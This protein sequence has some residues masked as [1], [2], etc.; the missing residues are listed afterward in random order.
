M[1]CTCKSHT[2]MHES[3][4]NGNG[5]GDGKNF[6]G[7]GREWG[8]FSLPCHSLVLIKREC[9]AVTCSSKWNGA[10]YLLVSAI[11]ILSSSLF[12]VDVAEVVVYITVYGQTYLSNSQGWHDI[13]QG[14]ISDTYPYFFNITLLLDVKTSLKCEN[15]ISS[16]QYCLLFNFKTFFTTR[17]T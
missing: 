13:Y 2:S 10:R 9:Q 12:T 7:M 16:F 8:W 14:Y 5:N 17:C 3:T 15:R 4:G 11:I 6:M 1:I